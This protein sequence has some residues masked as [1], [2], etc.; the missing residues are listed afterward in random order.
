MLR[1]PDFPLE[2][3]G[4]YDPVAKLGNFVGRP[5]WGSLEDV[6]EVDA[7]VV[8]ALAGAAAMHSLMVQRFGAGKVYAPSILRLRSAAIKPQV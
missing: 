6:P 2:V 5:L 7:W 1:A 4:T 8:T 3:V